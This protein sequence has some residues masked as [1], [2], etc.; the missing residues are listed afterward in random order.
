MRR[1]I[2][3]RKKKFRNRKLGHMRRRIRHR[4][5]RFHNHK[6]GLHR[7]RSNRSRNPS[8]SCYA[9]CREAPLGACDEALSSQSRNHMGRS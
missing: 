6:L 2:R 7:D 8:S 3:H 5:K 9:A 4:K 1:R